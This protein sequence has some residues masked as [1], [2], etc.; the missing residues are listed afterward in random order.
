MQRSD[1]APSLENS[2]GGDTLPLPLSCQLYR[3]PRIELF[4]TLSKPLSDFNVVQGSSMR[5]FLSFEGV[6]SRSTTP[7]RSP[8][9]SAFS[10]RSRW[11][12]KHSPTVTIR[13]PRPI[14]SGLRHR[15]LSDRE[16]SCQRNCV[17]QGME[18]PPV[19]RTGRRRAFVVVARAAG[20]F[21]R[22]DAVTIGLFRCGRLLSQPHAN[23]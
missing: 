15:P 21:L 8:I 2:R 10:F 9:R 7:S 14:G 17:F 4:W 13:T 12:D 1:L 18:P 16:P 20:C 6:C 19:S 3:Y 11:R 23:A 22:A 5:A